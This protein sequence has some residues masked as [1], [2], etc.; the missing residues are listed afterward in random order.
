MPKKK[1]NIFVTRA[2]PGNALKRLKKVANVKM[3]EKDVIIPRRELLKGAK[4]VDGLLPLLTDRI[5][6]EVLD[7]SDKLRIVA[8]YAVGFD[9][10]VSKRC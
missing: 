6:G 3:W 2:L 10:I 1:P 9:N 5:D 4:G 8:N 7:Q